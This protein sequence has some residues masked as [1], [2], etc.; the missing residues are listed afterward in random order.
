ML[1]APAG[2]ILSKPVGEIK[3]LS[4]AHSK[5]SFKPRAG[6][7]MTV[8]VHFR[9]RLLTPHTPSTCHLGPWYKLRHLLRTWEHWALLKAEIPVSRDPHACQRRGYQAP[10]A[11]HHGCLCL[12]P[13]PPHTDTTAP[14]SPK[15][16][17]TRF[18][19]QTPLM[20]VDVSNWC[21]ARGAD[22]GLSYSLGGCRHRLPQ[23][24]G[25]RR[26]LHAGFCVLAITATPDRPGREAPGLCN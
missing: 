25:W 7:R 15:G 9:S 24:R 16:P 22:S 1:A 8:C 13:H 4:C 21:T 11:S 3:S 17:P 10:L 19:I 20:R 26:G 23:W 5:V 6:I 12:P 14:M 2:P 18:L